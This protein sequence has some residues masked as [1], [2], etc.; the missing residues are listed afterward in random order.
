MTSLYPEGQELQAF[1]HQRRQRGRIGLLLFQSATL[2]GI[3]VLSVL[4]FNI[5]NQS[6]GLVAVQY[7][8]PPETLVEPGTTLEELP[9]EAL[10]AI[11]KKHLP[12]GLIR[13]FESE[14]PLVE[15]S[16]E[17]LYGLVLQRVV[18]PTTVKSW[19]LYDSIFRRKAIQAEQ[20]SEYPD[21]QLEFRSWLNLRFLT[22]QQSDKPDLA[23]VRPALKGSLL[24]ILITI[25]VA[26]PMGVSGAIYLE[27]YA[28]D[29]WFNRVIQTNISNL[30]G[31]PSIIYGL[32]GLAIFVRAM[33]P[34]TSGALFGLT[35]PATANGRT[36]LSA[37]LTLA[38][39]I[40]PLIIV[41]AQEA[42][43]AVPR[44]LRQASYGVGAT[45]W[46]TIWHHVLPQAMPGILTG[47]ILAV[48]RA[49]GETAPIV[50]VGA[51]TFVA[52][53]PT[54]PF[55][56]FTA[57]PMQIYQWTARPQDIYRNLAAAAI[58]TLL[59]MLLS[60]NATAILLRNRYRGKM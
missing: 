49:I 15:R 48:S 14:K 25:I 3:V 32:L 6:F 19:T 59:A 29:N 57:L 1:I 17:E 31:V 40:L 35:D 30:S 27:E 34:L 9:S 8:N 60:L 42:I 11:L 12:S 26:F 55:S 24:T 44:S 20:Q 38:L 54:G 41:N 2:I 50:V 21:A 28:T 18:D 10:I 13:R 4:L 56:R 22:N 36:I 23:G 52:L 47:T 39:L 37:G 5:I 16:Q 43:R 51:S 53:D 58:L 46:Q 7:R 33:N 45:Q